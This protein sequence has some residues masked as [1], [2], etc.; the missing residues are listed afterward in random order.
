MTR[1]FA[2]A[3]V[4][5]HARVL[6]VVSL[7]YAASG[8]G[9]VQEWDGAEYH[10]LAPL[11]ATLDQDGQLRWMQ[12]A[13]PHPPATLDQDGQLRWMRTSFLL[14]P[15]IRY[16]YQEGVVGTNVLLQTTSLIDVNRI[17]ATPWP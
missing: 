7:T 13:R 15:A 16:D 17:E 2:R 9:V 5:A 14:D 1:C 4:P 10:P 11:P 8:D 6:V 3:S 12:E